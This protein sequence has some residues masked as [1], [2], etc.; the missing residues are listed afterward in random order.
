MEYKL[1]TEP[2]EVYRGPL[3]TRYADYDEAIVW[4]S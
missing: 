3:K 4:E 2:R 1:F